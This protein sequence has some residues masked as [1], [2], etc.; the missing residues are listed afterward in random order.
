[1]SKKKPKL[2]PTC[3][4]CNK[5]IEGEPISR[6][7]VPPEQLYATV[8]KKKDIAKNLFTLQS[9]AACNTAFQH[10]EDYFV[11]SMGPLVG[12]SETGKQLW[13]DM[14]RRM[15]RDRAAALNQKI[16]DEFTVRSPGGIAAPPGKIFKKYDGDRIR[17]IVW[18]IVR[19]LF[20][21]ENSRFLPEQLH[22]RQIR[23]VSP[24]YPPRAEFE[25]LAGCPHKGQYGAVFDYKFRVAPELNNFNYWGL[26]FWD[27]LIVT[28]AFHD[29]ECP[30]DSCR[31]HRSGAPPQSK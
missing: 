10:D 1:M 17:K 7:H 31:A 8:Y 27:R 21:K 4:L 5:R 18:K 28:V 9:H 20:W 16:R 30:C 29:P 14:A 2:A 12:D 23:I 25:V 15:R 11:M 26:L 22:S 6:D 19:G 3:Y 24:H 13:E